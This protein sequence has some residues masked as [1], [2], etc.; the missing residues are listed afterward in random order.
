ML[1]SPD[2][3][4]IPAEQAVRLFWQT[5]KDGWLQRLWARILHKPMKLLELDV[6]LCCQQVQKQP[7]RRPPDREY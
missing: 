2:M 6:T 5:R 3:G 4:Q 1:Q 7:L